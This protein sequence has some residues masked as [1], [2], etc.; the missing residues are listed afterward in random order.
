MMASEDIHPVVKQWLSSWE[1]GRLEDLP[2]TDDF[3]HTSPFGSI[4]GKAR[5]LSI[6]GKNRADFL[7]NTFTVLAQITQGDRVCVQFEQN[8]HSTGLQMVVCEW[9]QLQGELIQSIHSFYNVGD[10]EIKG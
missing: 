9:Y 7:D 2:I 4:E 6:V 1:Q 5:Y 10:A 3:Q 8:N